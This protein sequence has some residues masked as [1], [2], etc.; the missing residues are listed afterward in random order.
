MLPCIIHEDDHLLVVDKPSGWNTHA[1]DPFANE[2]I[3]EWLRHREPRWASLATIHRLDKDTSGVL[4]FTKTP[5]A[6]RSLTEQ[7]T[8]RSVRKAYLLA[9]N[10]THPQ[11]PF[12]A[13]SCLV[14]AG[15]RYLSRPARQGG[16]LAETRFRPLTPEERRLCEED[17]SILPESCSLLVAEPLTGRT[18]QIR[19][20]AAEHGFPIFGDALYG[21]SGSTR[22]F[23]HAWTLRVRHPESGKATTFTAQPS[24]MK[25][26]ILARRRALIDPEETDAFRLHHGAADDAPGFY[27]DRLG[28][29]VLSQ[30]EGP[31]TEERSMLLS[32]LRATQPDCGTYHKQLNR[33]VRRTGLEDASPQPVQGREAPD[34][35]SV[36]ENGLTFE[37]S[38]QEGYSVG[39]FLD[40]RDN[41][42]RL[43]TRHI[44]KD[45]DLPSAFTLLNAFAYT[46]GFSVAAAAGGAHTTSLDL[47]KK[48]LAWG[49]RNL[50]LNGIN[51]AGHDFVFGDVFDWLKRF[52]K[53]GRRFQVIVLDPPTFSQ[54]KVSGVFRAERDYAKL[55]CSAAALLEPNGVLFC[56]SNAANWPPE[57]FLA[58]T[59]SG[60]RQANRRVAKSHYV[61]QPPD[62]PISREEPAYLKTA[63]FKCQ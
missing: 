27:V 36:R 24:L 51:P 31:I 19:V 14:R 40:Q 23:L 54:S 35:F 43:L 37:L 32:A 16:D 26:P 55:V 38:F 44:A 33:Q 10:R 48:Y 47:S 58:A 1:P 60:I 17:L 45:F 57:K 5:L 11:L 63:W 62:F 42:R 59:E 41:R 3:Y 50:E 9:T 28:Q 53:R 46:C 15:E 8:E 2:G 61:P 4:L 34:R 21:G 13:K 20:H 29:Y 22:V 56:S 30:A 25:P 39:L 7:F 12:T 52:A 6:N 49:R 18:H